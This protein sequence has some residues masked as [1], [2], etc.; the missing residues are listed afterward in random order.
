MA[1]R[2]TGAAAGPPL[3][4]A[5]AP[6]L[7]ALGY[8]PTPW[9]HMDGRLLALESEHLAAVTGVGVLVLATL[10]D[11]D[12]SARARAV[13]EARGLLAGPVR[14]GSDGAESRPLQCPTL[15]RP[16]HTALD[17]AVTLRQVGAVPL[18]G[19]WPRGTLLEV[20]RDELP[21]ISNADDVT[22]LF[23]ELQA[24]PSLLAAERRPPPKAS[25]KGWIR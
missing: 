13:L 8:M 20:Q 4:G 11:A 19:E 21:Q 18:D 10:S 9:G 16:E 17:G 3:F 5:A 2:K 25:R 7:R 12:L 22:R 24:L 14:V 15:W 1:D 23:E 6:R